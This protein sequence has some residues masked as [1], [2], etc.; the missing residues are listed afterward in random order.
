MFLVL[1]FGI[2][3]LGSFGFVSAT[4][5]YV[6][7]T[8]GS[9]SNNGLTPATAWKT[10]SKVNTASSG[11][12]P[13]D[14]IYFE[15][16]QTWRETL[17]PAS[18]GNSTD[19][20]TY[21]AYGEGERPI[22]NGA[23]I[24]TG[25]EEN[26]TNIWNASLA[27]DPR[28]VFFDGVMG[29]RKTGDCLSNLSSDGEWCHSGST[30]Y[31][32]SSSD[33]DL[34]YSSPGTEAAAR[35]FGV[36][37]DALQYL[38][39]TSL[40][41]KYARQHAFSFYNSQPSGNSLIE[42]C[43]ADYNRG[44]GFMF[45][46]GHN[47]N[48]VRNSFSNH[49]GNGFFVLESYNNTFV[50]CF[51]NDN[52]KYPYLPNQDG[53]GFGIQDSTAVIENSS[54]INDNGAFIIDSNAVGTTIIRN[55]YAFASNLLGPFAVG[56]IP[57][58]AKVYIYGNIVSNLLGSTEYYATPGD[59]YFY[60]NILFGQ[61]NGLDYNI[62]DYFA[63]ADNYHLKNNFYYATTS[64]ANSNFRIISL[65]TGS[66]E[67]DYN[68]F[69]FPNGITEISHDGINYPN[70]SSWSLASGQDNHSFSLDPRWLNT[71][72][73]MNTSSDFKLQWNSPAID[74]GTDVNLTT[75]YYGNPVY[76]NPD[77]GAIEYQPPYNISN[78]SINLSLSPNVRVYGDG[79]YRIFNATGLSGSANFSVSPS[80]G[81]SSY[82]STE[83]RPAMY[84]VNITNF[85]SSNVS[86]SVENLSSVGD[87]SF[88]IC[89]L[90]ASSYYS[91][92]VD[93][94][95][96]GTVSTNSN[97]CL[98]YEYTGSWSSHDFSL[99]FDSVIPVERE[100]ETNTGSSGG[101]PTFN[102]TE[103]Q[104]EEGYEH[105]F[106][107]GWKVSLTIQ[108]ISYLL[109]IKDIL[110]DRVNFSIIGKEHIIFSNETKKINLNEDEYYDLLI[111]LESIIGNKANL[112]FKEIHEEIPAEEQEEQEEKSK[113]EDESKWWIWL[114]FGAL[115]ILILLQIIFYFKKLRKRK[116]FMYSF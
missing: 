24:V 80:S 98:T 21:G 32:Y 56:S 96:N 15:R 38:N 8:T 63:N 64:T 99:V 30:L 4:N 23:D 109:E 82:S 5:Y 7:A 35:N 36:Y 86:W 92:S 97:G 40:E 42:N 71:S 104:L 78:Q 3:V 31:Q 68:S 25:W 89:N 58:G 34:R 18:S 33:P 90:T 93:S 66:I 107:K 65:I 49:N 101:I 111:V 105:Y 46:N 113:I 81:F 87:T 48:T 14:N 54:S 17:T 1:F 51:S 19:Y 88:T 39:V 43:V 84:D 72:G 11:F 67:S 28:I 76:G 22:I 9:D 69:Y 112:L 100:E 85:N 59:V 75:D 41:V 77:I 13:G 60:N 73:Y 52:I 70:I 6:N 50:S 91:L 47:N 106:Y 55:N 10:I 16:G 83:A 27:N 29:T 110:E 2:L 115:G 20:I 12:N 114:I 53:H 45:Y 37:V 102:P 94:G 108:N 61:G 103:E 57:S 44:A 79:K 74:A 116:R 62:A 26:T 95:S